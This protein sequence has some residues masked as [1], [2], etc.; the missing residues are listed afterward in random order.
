M[1]LPAVKMAKLI[2]NPHRDEVGL[3]AKAELLKWKYRAHTNTHT[4][5][6]NLASGYYLV[7]LAAPGCRGCTYT[8]R[9]GQWR[10]ARAPL[11]SS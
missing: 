10:V 1:S 4:E 6:R 11:N 9:G 3:L 8:P 5:G 2:T 7:L